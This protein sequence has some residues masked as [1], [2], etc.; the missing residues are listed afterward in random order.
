MIPSYRSIFLSHLAR[1]A[2]DVAS[3]APGGSGWGGGRAGTSHGARDVRA[4]HVAE[5]HV[6]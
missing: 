6:A 4:D 1:R 5:L 3:I 2:S